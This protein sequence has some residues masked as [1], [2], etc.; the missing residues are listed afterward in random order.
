MRQRYDVSTAL[1]KRYQWKKIFLF[2]PSADKCLKKATK[3]KTIKKWKESFKS[4]K[5]IDS[6]KM[7]CT[8]CKAHE[9][10]LRLTPGANL[11]FVT[12][13]TNYNPSTLKDHKETDGHKRAEKETEHKKAKAA[14]SELP[15]RKVS[16]DPL[17]Q[18]PLLL[19]GY[20][21]WKKTNVRHLLS[22]II[23]PTK[24]LSKV[25]LLPTSKMR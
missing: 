20:V 22:S 15:P 14:E 17:L 24:S 18:T 8:T 21:K 19:K 12:G 4:L 1:I 7:V 13:S 10:K 16:Q 23:L 9:E 5:F 2:L 3:N 11:T 25:C 6:M